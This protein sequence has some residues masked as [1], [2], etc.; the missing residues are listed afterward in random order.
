MFLIFVPEFLVC[1]AK[2]RTLVLT[3]HLMST[4]Q[5]S[6]TVTYSE[7]TTIRAENQK[8]RTMAR[9]FHL[10]N[11]VLLMYQLSLVLI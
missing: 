10:K 6:K 4:I 1:H 7:I 11:F 2:L 9:C 3:Y 5:S 8:F